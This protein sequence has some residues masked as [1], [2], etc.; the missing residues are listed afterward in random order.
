MF[1]KCVSTSLL[2]T[3]IAVLPVSADE[4]Y[5]GDKEC[6]NC[7]SSIYRDYQ[8]SGHPYKLQKTWGRAPQY[9]S[10]TS[11]G[12]PHPPE[13]MSWKDISYVIG[14]FAW[15]ARFLDNEG[16]ILTGKEQ[17]QYNL[18]NNNLGTEPHWTG[19]SAKTAPRKPYTC[20]SCHTTGWEASGPDG[21]HQDGLQGIYGTWALPGVTCEACHGP[22]SEHVDEP[23]KHNLAL[24]ENCDSC[25]RRKDPR[26]IDASKGLIRHHEQYEGLLAS[27]HKYLKCGSC[28]E[29]HKSVK[30]GDGFKGEQATCLQCHESHIPEAAAQHKAGCIDCHMPAL[31]KS[32]VFKQLEMKDGS[33]PLG[34]VRSHIFSIHP[35]PDWQMFSDEGKRV[36]LDSNNRAHLNIRYSCIGCHTDKDLKWIE[37]H[38]GKFLK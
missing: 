24:E 2:F 32:A 23:E 11:P 21:P 33:F 35:S 14:G 19:Y 10:N 7:H 36:A 30:Y 18:P 12:V 28:H 8:R 29:P 17:R 6:R 26:V 1:R 20:G 34:D 4:K 22:A 38:K 37:E 25:H 16:Y 13:G 31:A 27:A 9:P 5:V 3:L 15:K